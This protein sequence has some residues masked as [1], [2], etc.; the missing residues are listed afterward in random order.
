MRQP[1]LLRG[2]GDCGF[3]PRRD[4]PDG[5]E[6]RLDPARDEA[7]KKLGVDAM[8][9]EGEEVSPACGG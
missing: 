8:E 9:D 4:Q 6:P 1:G 7:V 3:L 2:G 5:G